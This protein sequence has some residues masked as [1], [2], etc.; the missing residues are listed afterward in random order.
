M[1]DIILSPSDFVSLL[2]Q[3]LEVA[4]PSVTIEGELSN[5]RVSKNRWL[6]FDLHDEQASVK[7]FGT[8]Y[9]LPGPLEDGLKIRVVGSPRMHPRFGFSVNVSSIS[10]VGEGSIKKAAQLL[11]AKLT[12]E[13]LFDSARKRLLPATPETIG[14]ITAG[15]SAAYADFIKIL[16]E[17]WGGVEV[18]LADVYVQGAQAP[19]QIVQ[20]IEYFN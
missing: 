8:V 13:G 6:Y 12:A 20:A 3:T 10:P 11:Q 7:F 19:A 18:Q 17:R 5:F 4:Y 15:N 9:N 14:L 2:N 1:D 16:N